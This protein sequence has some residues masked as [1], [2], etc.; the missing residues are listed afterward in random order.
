LQSRFGYNFVIALL[1][2]GG[3]R[4]LKELFAALGLAILVASS[5]GAGPDGRD[6]AA[7]VVS[8]DD[9]VRLPSDNPSSFQ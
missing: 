7:R 8:A 2:K 9:P 6:T 4:A 5:S 3:G 1:N